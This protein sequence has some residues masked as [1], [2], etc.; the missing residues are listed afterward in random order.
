MTLESLTRGLGGVVLLAVGATLG[1]AAVADDSPRRFAVGVASAELRAW[2]RDTD[3]VALAYLLQGTVVERQGVVDGYVK[4]RLEGYVH[5]TQL[6]AVKVAPPAPP[7]DA[8]KRKEL[9]DLS[10]ANHVAVTSELVEGEGGRR[11]VIDARYQSADGRPVVPATARHAGT[12]RIYLQRRIAGGLARGDELL[13]R[14]L[15]FV[16]GAAR[17]ELP[18]RELGDPAP[19][20]VL[21]S[22]RVELAAGRELV[23]AESERVLPAR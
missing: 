16:D 3:G 5:A 9:T 17:L 13:T 6:A 7:P 2:P 23:G 20:M 11:L 4:V 8:P 21:L 15:A 14:E 18:L 1:G 10:R 22:A 19:A 12:L